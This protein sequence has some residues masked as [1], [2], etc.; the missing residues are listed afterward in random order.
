MDKFHIVNKVVEPKKRKLSQ[1][2]SELAQ[3]NAQ[4]KDKQDALQKVLD[5]VAALESQLR[6]AQQEQQ[7][8]NEQVLDFSPSSDVVI[9]Q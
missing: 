5:Q 4:L 1:A 7:N 9:L 8:L 6:Q 2:E 3:A